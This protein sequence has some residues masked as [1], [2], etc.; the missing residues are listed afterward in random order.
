MRE[1]AGLALGAKH[2]SKAC[3]KSSQPYFRPLERLRLSMSA[4][5]AKRPIKAL[6]KLFSLEAVL[7]VKISGE[8]AFAFDGS[9]ALTSLWS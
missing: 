3:L 1:Q 2:R 6:S 8:E 7:E 4:R 9:A 5:L